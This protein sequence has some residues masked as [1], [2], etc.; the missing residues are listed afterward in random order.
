MGEQIEEWR[1]VVGYEG[2]YE[3]SSLGNVRSLDR[4]VPC[5]GGKLR[6]HRG[7]VL[8]R[9]WAPKVG[10]HL[11]DLYSEGVRCMRPIGTLVAEA[12]IGPRPP[13][14]ELC[15]NNGDSSNDSVGNLR[16]DTRA[17]NMRDRVRHGTHHK[18]NKT[19]C[20]RGHE[21]AGDNL[22]MDEGRRRCRTCTR[23]RV[24]D[25]ARRVRASAA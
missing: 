14:Y 20:P 11:I 12:F 19:H 5:R 6:L 9:L 25:C 2:L 21:Y 1:A 16:W 13:G 3:V 23:A 8:A 18:K 22:M 4:Y 7:K 10:R 15:H 24:N 17:E